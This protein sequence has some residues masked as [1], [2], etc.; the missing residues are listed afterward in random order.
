MDHF[1]FISLSPFLSDLR[2]AFTVGLPIL[3]HRFAAPQFRPPPQQTFIRHD[4]SMNDAPKRLQDMAK[5]KVRSTQRQCDAII[6]ADS[7]PSRPFPS[8]TVTNRTLPPTWYFHCWIRGELYTVTPQI[9]TKPFKE[10]KPRSYMSSNSLPEEPE[11]VKVKFLRLMHGQ[12]ADGRGGMYAHVL[13]AH[14]CLAWHPGFFV[15][16]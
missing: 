7:H 15:S 4:P 5:P 2:S 12:H 1:G 14:A 6:L 16:C 9:L 10:P 3:L 11:D 13:H 8:T